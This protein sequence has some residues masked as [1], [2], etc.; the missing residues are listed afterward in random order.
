MTTLYKAFAKLWCSVLLTVIVTHNCCAQVK[1]TNNNSIRFCLSNNNGL[2]KI[3]G[4][5]ANIPGVYFDEMLP[6]FFQRK[7]TFEKFEL[8]KSKLKWIFTGIQGGITVTISADTIELVQRYYDSYGFN[9]MQNN[10]FIAK[11]FPQ[12]DFLLTKVAINTISIKSIMVEVNH[13]LGLKLYV[14]DNKVSEQLTQIDV[15]KHQLQTIGT[16]INVCGQLE[17]PQVDEVK[18]NIL[19]NMKHQ[20][21]LGFGGITSPIAYSLLSQQGK[22]KWW[23]LLKE[24]NLLIQ[25]EYPIGKKLKDDYSNWDKLANA[26]PHYYGDN[27]PN[28]EVTDFSYNKKIQ[29]LGGMVVFEFWELPD[30]AV[31]KDE[32][33]NKLTRI[34]LYDKYTA[35]IVNY[36][37]NSK[38]KTG[39]APAIVGIQNEVTQPDEVWRE[40]T[41][42]LREA[43]NK[44]GFKDVAIHMHNAVTLNGGAKAVSA[45]SHKNTV[46]EK[47]NYT[48]SN[49]YDY[50]NYF[51]KPNSFDTV[52]N[53]WS[54]SLK[55]KL[56]K[57]FL[58]VEMCVNDAKYQSG[59]YKIAFLM[60]ELYH[61]NMVQLNAVSLMYC[62]LLINTV[63]PSFAASRSL[64]TI[65]ESSN[66]IPKASSYQLRVFGAFS[67]HL[68]K[69]MQRIEVTSSD[70]DLLA[71][72]YKKEKNTVLIVLN[73][74]NATKRIA[75]QNFS[76]KFSKIEIVSPY[77]QN[78]ILDIKTNKDLLIEPGSIVT[79]F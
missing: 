68:L 77:M 10:E 35:A 29:D 19:N 70:E 66:N 42:K 79:F 51:T 72:A 60:G 32:T 40:M 74:S 28:G 67:R 13:A 44:N 41:I 25:R 22:N 9:K 8:N 20:E 58:S 62:W 15:S 75:L 73:K 49:I 26:T 48:A 76:S 38:L 43:L 6:A 16:T 31:K 54:D 5:T 2:E 18:L 56:T 39:K 52:I 64:F 78:E 46:W 69:G 47:I 53:T 55:G 21:I 12:S 1:F 61:K 57:P 30:W 34:P 59:S 23:S 14:N 71:S 7:I 27:F 17:T 33:N 3:W 36:C 45:F 65:D 63:Q 11:R 50:Q 4:E 24:Y 37:I